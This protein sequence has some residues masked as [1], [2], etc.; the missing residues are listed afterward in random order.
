MSDEFKLLISTMVRGSVKLIPSLRA[1][2]DA[3]LDDHVSY[4]FMIHLVKEFP[5]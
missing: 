4:R 3:R 5:L 1:T 2:R